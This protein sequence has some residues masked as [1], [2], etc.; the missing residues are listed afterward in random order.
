MTQTQPLLAYV[1]VNRKTYVVLEY[2]GYIEFAEE[3]VL[4]NIVQR[5]ITIY[6][7]LYVITDV[8]IQSISRGFVVSELLVGQTADG[9]HKL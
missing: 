4:R 6:I 9:E 5:Q 3:K 2:M 1:L 7:M 8:L